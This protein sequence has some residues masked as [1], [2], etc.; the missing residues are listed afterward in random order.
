MRVHWYGIALTLTAAGAAGAQVGYPPNQS[1]FRDLRE[2]QEITFYSGYFRAKL[3]PARVVPRSG[4][5]V[6]LHYQ[7]RASGPA[8][9]T[10]DAARVESERRVLDPEATG[11]CEVK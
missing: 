1:P 8:N 11:F 3:D 4:P 7:W 2:R 5:I 6:G 10:L 9:L